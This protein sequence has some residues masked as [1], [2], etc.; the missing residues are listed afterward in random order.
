MP[1]PNA[2]EWQDFYSKFKAKS[3]LDLNL[4]K[5]NQLQRRIV[6]MMDEKK[7]KSLAEFWSS[8][9]KEPGGVTWLQD[10]L[11]INVSELFRN[12]EKFRELE[13]KTIPSLLERSRTLKI[14]SA[15]CSYGAE[16]HSVA[17]ILAKKFPGGHQIVGSDIDQAAL[18]QAKAGTFCE[19]DMRGVPA[20]YREYFSKNDKVW[21]AD[22]R[23]R[24][25][26]TFRRGNLLADRFDSG[27]DLILC[28][29]VVIYFT[30]E[31]KD[32]LYKKFFNALKPGGY[33]LVG[34][35]ERIF[36]S[37]AIGF[38]QDLPFFYQKPLGEQQS[39][40]NAS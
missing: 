2:A 19:A 18:D 34:S 7:A 39:W 10:K 13:Q 25:Y 35:T 28:R 9:A 24:K 38:T 21:Q 8:L 30:D 22:Q 14:W 5:A 15:G 33:L 17:A 37:E 26:L 27:L 12:P 6:S 23:I 1:L 20:E 36:K 11:A 4:Y 3:G 29:N 32:E 31:A 40:R 16:A